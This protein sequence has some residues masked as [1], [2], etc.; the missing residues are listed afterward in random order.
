M[1]EMGEKCLAENYEKPNVFFGANKCAR[2]WQ[3]QRI[4]GR[5]K[6]SSKKYFVTLFSTTE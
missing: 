2:R 6:I 3:K 4:Y 5:T 1:V